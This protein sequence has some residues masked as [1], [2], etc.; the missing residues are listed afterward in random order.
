M[1]PRVSEWASTRLIADV[2]FGSPMRSPSI[3]SLGGEFLSPRSWRQSTSTLVAPQQQD[4][5]CPRDN[6]RADGLSPCCRCHS[7]DARFGPDRRH[8]IVSVLGHRIRDNVDQDLIYCQ[9]KEPAAADWVPSPNLP[10]RPS[11]TARCGP[12]I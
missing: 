10:Q 1:K 12:T 5:H 8:H 3:L 2:R 7:T 4:R 11:A 9:G 6:H